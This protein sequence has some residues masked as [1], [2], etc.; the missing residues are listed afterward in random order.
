MAIYGPIAVGRPCRKC[1]R[2]GH[3]WRRQRI[4]GRGP[5]RLAMAA[6]APPRHLIR[7]PGSTWIHWVKGKG[8]MTSESSIC[9]G[10]SFF[11]SHL[12]F[13][14]TFQRVKWVEN[15]IE[16]YWNSPNAPSKHLQIIPRECWSRNIP[17]PPPSLGSSTPT[18]PS[19]SAIASLH[20]SSTL[21]E[22]NMAVM[23]AWH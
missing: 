2:P 4:P 1:T 19:T 7:D 23:A 10:R 5:G 3:L 21:W 16:N 14:E 18:Q 17:W 9:L 22:W 12:E 13:I 15:M 11:V 20:R 6:R 8:P